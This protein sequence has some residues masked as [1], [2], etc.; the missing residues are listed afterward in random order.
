MSTRARPRAAWAAAKGWLSR[1]ASASL[2]LPAG[3]AGTGAGSPPRRPRR[4]PPSPGP[5]GAVRPGPAARCAP[6]RS[7]PPPRRRSRPPPRPARRPH[8]SRAPRRRRR[9]RS[10]PA[11]CPACAGRSS[12]RAGCPAPSRS[13]PALS[14][15]ARSRPRLSP[16]PTPGRPLPGSIPRRGPVSRSMACVPRG[17]RRLKPAER[18][19]LQRRAPG[20]G[21]SAQNATAAA[22]RVIPAPRPPASGRAAPGSTT[23]EV[24]GFFSF[25][26]P[27]RS[28]RP[29]RSRAVR[30]GPAAW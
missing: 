18:R 27:R 30:R 21:Q 26:P 1:R 24:L 14:R 17:H 3:P 10:S 22:W 11:R 19:R 12:G 13:R 4:P 8:R 28:R 29:G 6:R 9:P 16:T 15:S 25:G 7:G 2:R 20:Q 23:F 5:P